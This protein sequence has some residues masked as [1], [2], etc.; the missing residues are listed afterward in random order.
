MSD[1]SDVLPKYANAPAGWVVVS[2]MLSL[3]MAMR[4]LLVAFS[5]DLS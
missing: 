4:V 3:W 5:Q 2:V 1:E